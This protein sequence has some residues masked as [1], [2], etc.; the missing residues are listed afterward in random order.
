MEETDW[1]QLTQDRIEWLT[2]GNLKEFCQRE[3]ISWPV[4]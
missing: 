3:E 2:L 4:Q 1:V